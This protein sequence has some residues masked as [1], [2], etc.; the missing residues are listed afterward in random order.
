MPNKNTPR[1]KSMQASS[2]ESVTLSVLAERVNR[3]LSD[4]S[5]DDNKI[6]QVINS[7]F[8]T[9]R[10]DI[11]DNGSFKLLGFGTF[12]RMLVDE[13]ERTDRVTGETIFTPGYY[14][15]KFVPVSALAKRVNKPYEHLQPEV[16]EEAPVEEEAKPEP[17]E[18]PIDPA[19]EALRD[20]FDEID[21][22]DIDQGQTDEPRFDFSS[23]VPHSAA[24]ENIRYAPQ[25]THHAAPDPYAPQSAPYAAPDHYVQTADMSHC[26]VSPVYDAETQRKRS[27]EIDGKAA[28]ENQT[29]RHA[30]IQQQIIEQQIVQQHVI[31]NRHAGELPETEDNVYDTDY[32]G[33]DY[34]EGSQRYISRCWF[35]AGVAVVLTALMI[36][37]LAYVLTHRTPKAA[38]K[39]V[40]E[41]PKTVVAEPKTVV[42]E[43]APEIR[44][45]SLRIAADDNLY[46][47]LAQAEY[48]ERNLW[49]YIFS[50]NMLRYPDPDNPGAARELVVPSKPDRAIDR[51]DIELSVIDVYDSYR[52]LIAANPRGRA[53]AIRKEHAVISLICGESLY[54]GFIDKYAI[55]FNVED[56]STAREQIKNAAR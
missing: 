33:D 8:D 28:V 5:L 52:S 42:T 14:K 9:V 47:A 11:L 25:F 13:K 51:R 18:T 20:A 34:E 53:A 1:E 16:I 41:M 49:P 38:A 12:D 29:V 36:G 56:V 3:R 15:I 19:A 37:A 4:K 30:V 2:T 46:A 45:V 35:F 17:D 39:S 7:F 23:E 10:R 40:R 21:D 55:R 31:Q 26:S 54:S 27:G 32:D 6:K 48:G 24:S 22:P 44:T 43:A 50:A